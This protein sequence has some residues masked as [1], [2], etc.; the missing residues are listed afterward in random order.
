M[1]RI[2]FVAFIGIS[3]SLS[4]PV[5]S[6]DREMAKSYAELFSPVAGA[7][8][9]K[10]LHLMKPADFVNA[11]KAGKDFVVIDIRTPAE[12]DIFTVALPNHLVIPANELFQPEN[13][14]RIPTDKTVVIICSSGTRSIA[15]GTALRHIGLENIYILKGGFKDL[16]SY[17]GPSEAN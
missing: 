5:W 1:R 7:E 11:L 17:L 13:L 12:T 14:D 10:A 2:L 6:Y 3:M 9:G 15:V 4:C 8:A 16:S